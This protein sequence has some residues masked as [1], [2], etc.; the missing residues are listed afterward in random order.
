[1]VIGDGGE[2]DGCSFMDGDGERCFLCLLAT[3]S[4]AVESGGERECR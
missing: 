3:R 2:G 1:M 4:P